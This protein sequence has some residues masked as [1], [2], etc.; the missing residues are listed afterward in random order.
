MQPQ[1]R[2]QTLPTEFPRQWRLLEQ[3]M[4]EISIILQLLHSQFP[5]D[6]LTSTHIESTHNGSAITVVLGEGRPSRPQ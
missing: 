1:T 6:G 2:L 3:D 4:Y 5:V